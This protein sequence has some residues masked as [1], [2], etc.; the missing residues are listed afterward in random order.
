[1]KYILFLLFIGI[2]FLVIGLTRKS[3]SK[4][5]KIFTLLT[6]IGILLIIGSLMLLLLPGSSALLELLFFG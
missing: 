5:L 4:D 3:V 6:I 2:I 1:M